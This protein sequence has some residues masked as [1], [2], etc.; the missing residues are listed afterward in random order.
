L[1]RNLISDLVLCHRC[2]CRR[3]WRAD[4]KTPQ[5]RWAPESPYSFGMSIYRWHL[6]WLKFSWT[7]YSCSCY[8]F[9]SSS[10]SFW[11]NLIGY[12]VIRFSMK[13]QTFILFVLHG[14]HILPDIK[15]INIHTT[16]V[17]MAPTFWCACEL[18]WGAASANGLKY[19]KAPPS[20]NQ[21]KWIGLV[22]SFF[23]KARNWM[24]LPT[25]PKW[26]DF[27]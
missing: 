22:G 5:L 18:A 11:S 17:F 19:F 12:P 25:W 8:F 1:E 10:T 13:L 3:S 4:Q 14:K 21:L 9:L 20:P 6:C 23:Q 27:I 2:R 16:K 15:N 26:N 24:A 7:C